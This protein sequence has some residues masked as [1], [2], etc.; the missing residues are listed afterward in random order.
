MR[1]TATRMMIEH[2]DSAERQQRR[3][4]ALRV[5]REKQA[6]M[7]AMMADVILSTAYQ[8]EVPYAESAARGWR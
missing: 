2:K 7:E 3:A 5:C 1:K 4:D 8:T 6:A